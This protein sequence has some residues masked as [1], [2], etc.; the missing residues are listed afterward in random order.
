VGCVMVGKRVVGLVVVAGLLTAAPAFAEGTATAGTLAAAALRAV[1][2]ADSAVH[3]IKPSLVMA[4]RLTDSALRKL[5]TADAALAADGLN[6]G[7]TAD[8]RA[9][10]ENARA[11]IATA[12]AD[13]T[14]AQTAL[15][16]ALQH[17]QQE[18]P[19]AT[20]VPTHTPAPTHTPTPTR[21]PTPHAG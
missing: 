7:R 18:Q 2:S 16:A 17:T 14:D 9:K 20:R 19:T 8:A 5:D 13:A 11:A 10:L 12:E 4:G 1:R 6:D 21:T 15:D 3:P